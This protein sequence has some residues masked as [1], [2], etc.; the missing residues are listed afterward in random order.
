M[1]EN[2]KKGAGIAFFVSALSLAMISAILRALNLFF[3]F[4]SSLGYYESGA[5]LPLV[6]NILLGVGAIFF[7]VFAFCFFR[8]EKTEYSAPSVIQISAS[9]ISAASALALTVGRNDFWTGCCLYPLR[10]Y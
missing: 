9:A 8:K 7:I 3:F 2:S 6:S 4:D 10:I 1:N 5:A